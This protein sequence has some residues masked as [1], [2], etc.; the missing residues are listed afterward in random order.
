M[1]LFPVAA[2]SSM[3]NMYFS[4]FYINEGLPYP[5]VTKIAQDA[6]GYIWIGAR[7]GLYRYDGYTIN[8]VRI[9]GA[10]TISDSHVRDIFVRTNN[11]TWVIL[12][13]QVMKYIPE[14]DMLEKYPVEYNPEESP[15]YNNPVLKF[16]ESSDGKLFFLNDSRLY[17]LNDKTG[18]FELFELVNSEVIHTPFYE[19]TADR[20]NG[21]WLVGVNSL[22]HIDLN[23]NVI[24]Q[25][26]VKKYFTQEKMSRVKGILVDSE[27][28]LWIATFGDGLLF[29][30]VRTGEFAQLNKTT[31]YD[32]VIARVLLEDADHHLWVG[33]ENGLRVL[34]IKTR[35]LISSIK[36]DYT[37]NL[38][39]NDDAM[40]AA[41]QD[42]EQNIWFGTYFSGINILYRDHQRFC[43][44]QPG[45]KPVNV[46]GKAVRQI[47]E[48]GQFLWIAT[49]DGGLNRFDKT[50]RKFFHYKS[51]DGTISGNNVHALLKDRNGHLWIGTFDGGVNVM[52]PKNSAFRYYNTRNTPLF[53]NDIIFCFLEDAEGLIYIGTTDGLVIYHPKEDEFSEIDHPVLK[54]RFIYNLTMDKQNNIWIATRN[55]GLLHYNTA[56]KTI[57]HYTK[58]AQKG[59]LGDNSI[60]KI[61]EDSFHN[62]W[63]GTN[64]AGLYVFDSKKDNFKHIDI[65]GNCCVS[66]MVEDDDK[67]LWVSVEKGLVRMN[68]SDHSTSVFSTDDGLYSD[69]FNANSALK[70]SEGELFFGTINGLISFHPRDVGQIKRQLN[71]VFSKL[72]INGMEALAGTPDSPLKTSL[73]ESSKIT[74]TYQQA[75]AIAIEYAAIY[76]GHSKNIQYAVMMEGIDDNWNILNDQRRVNYSKLPVGKYT[77]KV[78]AISP[79]GDWDKADVKSILIE[80]EPPFYLSGWAWVIY[81][82]LTSVVVLII[83]RFFKIRQLEKEQVQLEKMERTKVEE[84]NRTKIDF[85]TNISHELKT[86]LTL[87]ISPLQRI[88]DKSSYKTESAIKETMEVILNNAQRMLRIVDELMTFSKIEIGKEKLSL[89]KGN[90]LEFISNISKIFVLLSREKGIYFTGNIED[91]GEEVWFSIPNIEKIVYNLLS[92]SF[93][94]TPPEGFVSLQAFLTEG[95]QN[96][97]FLEIIVSDSGVGIHKEY[98]NRIFENY[99][100]A[101][102]N[103]NI[104]GSGIG[105]S[106]TKRLVN[107]HKGDIQVESEI[108]KGSTFRVRIDVSENSYSAEEKNMEIFNKDFFKHYNYIT[109]EKDIVD[110]SNSLLQEQEEYI[111]SILLAD[112][113]EELLRFLCSIFKNEYRIFTAGN[114]KEALE[115]VKKKYPDLIISDIMM[116][117]MDGLEFCRQVKNNFDTCHIPVILLTAKTNTG[118]KIEGYET[119]ADYYIEKPFNAQ[120]LEIQVQNIIKTRLSNIQAFKSNPQD[121]AK[122]S[123]NERDSAFV[124]KLTALIEENM[125]NQFFSISDIT[126]SLNVSRTLLHVKCKKLIDTSVTD[127]IREIRM[128]KAKSLLLAGCNISETAYATGYSDP[129]YFTKVFKK[130]FDTT[131]SDFLRMRT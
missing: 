82:L 61:Y 49:E 2:F 81:F 85:F 63:V 29:Y 84:V 13:N 51:G 79:N 130:H 100:Q 113:N 112:D 47:I 98:L 93:K 66:S 65:L 30:D 35:T 10:D 64:S 92:N 39:M 68:P 106:L 34:D 118:D 69:W 24:A 55:D 129:G 104:R 127:Y 102:P 41:F 20:A 74:L 14:K 12:N 114:G 42:K 36:Q 43:Y 27:N 53:K 16:A 1:L 18:K 94:F 76:Y 9:A 17:R 75:N 33:G 109:I 52:N 117:E 32:I 90:V 83:F 101:D 50:T 99:F 38:G 8:P 107:L 56:N 70:T 48:D 128:N 125:D 25:F 103:S 115:I 87:I 31:G 116:P 108:G 59:S 54:A 40:Y 23:S 22:Y 105:L 71:V 45:Y 95:E 89:H 7:K 60:T 124:E 58:N 15:V 62:I 120:L 57:K 28:N 126:K 110:K 121:I 37:N 72:Y 96:R 86:P 131:P 5:H 3:T 77:F 46:S 80:V 67:M 88:I 73:E 91:N 11:D 119:G 111:N 122:I 78:R 123:L 4:H 44:Y 21:L 19:F 26:D 97:L 6:K